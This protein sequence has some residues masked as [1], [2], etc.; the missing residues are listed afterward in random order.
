MTSQQLRIMSKEMYNLYEDGNDAAEKVAK[1]LASARKAA[2]ALE[3]VAEKGGSLGGF[4]GSARR[5]IAAAVA[6]YE[7]FKATL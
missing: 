5:E 3:A 6:K 7:T 2:L 4:E 1:V